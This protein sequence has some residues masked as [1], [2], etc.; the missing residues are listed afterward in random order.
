[1]ELPLEL[2]STLAQSAVAY[3]GLSTLAL[4]V[5]QLAGVRWQ[6]QMTTGFWLVIAWSLGAFVFSVVPLLLAECNISVESVISIASLGLAI[7]VLAV[8]ASALRR[9]V[10]LI[11]AGETGSAR[12]PVFTMIAMGLICTILTL[13]LVLNAFSLL[14]GPRQAWYVASVC[15]LFLFAIVP[16]VHLL[17]AVQQKE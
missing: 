9:D 17:A 5:V 11:K 7:F 10:R 3:A 16:L 15:A 1:M 6:A 2:L 4:V 13:T 14:P 8:F 12:P